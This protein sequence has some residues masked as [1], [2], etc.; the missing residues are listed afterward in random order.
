[1][2][3]YNIFSAHCTA[4]LS[5]KN[6]LSMSS[7]MHKGHAKTQERRQLIAEI[8]SATYTRIEGKKLSLPK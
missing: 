2:K 3:K 1:M 4:E 8:R 5:E 6:E 7:D